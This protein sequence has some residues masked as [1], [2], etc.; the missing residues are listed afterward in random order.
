MKTLILFL[1]ALPAYANHAV[2]ISVVRAHENTMVVSGSSLHK[3]HR[4]TLGGQVVR[5]MPA[6][7]ELVIYCRKLDKAPCANDRWIPGT[8]TLRLFKAGKVKPLTTYPVTITGLEKQ[9]RPV[10]PETIMPMPVGIAP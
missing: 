6:A 2:D 5:V 4:A 3:V 1:L 9:D 7:S 10:P 8:Y